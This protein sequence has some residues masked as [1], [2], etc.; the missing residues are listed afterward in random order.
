MTK[1]IHPN[2]NAQKH[3]AVAKPV[4]APTPIRPAAAPSPGTAVAVKDRNIDYLSR[5]G[6]IGQRLLALRCHQPDAP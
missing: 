4:S 5:Y 1:T 6:Q 2:V 3:V